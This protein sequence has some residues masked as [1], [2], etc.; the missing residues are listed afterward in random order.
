[1]NDED[2]IKINEEELMEYCSAPN[3]P[4]ITSDELAEIARISNPKS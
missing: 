2:P 3:T 1:M 4:S